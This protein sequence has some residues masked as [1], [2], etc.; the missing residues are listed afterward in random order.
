M[1]SIF[2]MRHVRT[3]A[4]L[5]S[6]IPLACGASP[7]A[8]GGGED[9]SGG[10]GG[11][12]AGSGGKA[13]AGGKGGS[14]GT[15]GVIRAAAQRRH[16]RRRRHAG[17]RWRRGGKRWQAR[18]RRWY[19]QWRHGRQRAPPA[20]GAL[21]TPEREA[22]DKAC[23]PKFTLKLDGH[24]SRGQ[25]FTEAVGGNAEAFVQQIGREVCR[26]LYRKATEVRAANTIEL[27]IR[28]YDGV[29][30]KWG[31]IGD[32]GVEISTRHLQNVKNEG[33]DV[34]AEIAGIL[35]HE[36]THMYQ[37]DD[38]PEGTFSGLANMYE[39]IGDAVRIRNGF[40]P[41]GARPTR[42]GRWRTRPTPGRRSSGCTSTPRTPTSSTS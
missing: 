37:N 11:K 15:G 9:D 23:T 17:R 12:T 24:G 26:V 34:R 36:M 22:L 27:N 10:S 6:L 41:A 29:A 4:L 38:K 42:S 30:A 13:S 21:P 7:A 32:I 14:P 19:G 2:T 28:D 20:A 35:Q 39:G 8:P 1:V 33:R 40:A 18:R 25:L 5:G 16:D 31:D 3:F